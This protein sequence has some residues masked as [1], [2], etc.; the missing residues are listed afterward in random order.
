MSQHHESAGNLKAGAWMTRVGRQLQ[1]GSR[2]DP[3]L[4]LH[5]DQL[6]PGVTASASLHQQQALLRQV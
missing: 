3:Y 2:M 1:L 5:T 6:E 4:V